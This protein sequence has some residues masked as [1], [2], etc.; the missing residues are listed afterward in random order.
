MSSSSSSSSTSDYVPSTTSEEEEEEEGGYATESP[1]EYPPLDIEAPA[2]LFPP[3][4]VYD[5]LYE[6]NLIE[7]LVRHRVVQPLPADLQSPRGIVA[8]KAFQ[9]GNILLR[10]SSHPQFNADFVLRYPTLPWSASSVSSNI[11]SLEELQRLHRAFPQVLFF[12]RGGLSSNPHVDITWVEAF[13]NQGWCL[14]ALDGLSSAPR[15]RTEWIERLPQ[16]QH[17]MLGNFGVS[18]YSVGLSLSE[19]VE[20]QDLLTWGRFGLSENPSLERS[21]LQRFPDKPWDWQCVQKNP[22]FCLSWLS[23]VPPDEHL[24][25]IAANPVPESLQQHPPPSPS[26]YSLEVCR[27]LT[28]VANT[29]TLHAWPPCLIQLLRRWDPARSLIAPQLS[30][31]PGN[32]PT[33][34]DRFDIDWVEVF[35]ATD[36]IFGIAPLVGGLSCHRNAHVQWVRRYPTRAWDFGYGGLSSAPNLRLS[37]I[38]NMPT[39]GWSQCGILA[40]PNFSFDWV[41]HLLRIGILSPSW[42]SNMRLNSR[43]HFSNDIV[44]RYN[45]QC[46][47]LW[48][49]CK[50]LHRGRVYGLLARTAATFLTAA[51]GP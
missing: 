1:R 27:Y 42:P 23:E 11:R 35:P 28:F 24:P 5:P 31:L 29:R 8:L 34:Y 46:R 4:P 15:F 18:R 43:M 45:R 22:R 49:L 20:H 32:N 13:P 9:S 17:L 14:H 26:E 3:Q 21:W 19:I 16:S 2:L 44:G 12:G 7:E 47:A 48:A 36:W 51:T 30:V 25:S 41:P 38:L 6:F 40:N 50:V 37:W 10:I 39:A 33:L